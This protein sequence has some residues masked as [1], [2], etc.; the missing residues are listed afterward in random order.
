M[1]CGCA[2]HAPRVVV[3]YYVGVECHAHAKLLECSGSQS[4]PDCKK[5]VL[6]YD[7]NCEQLALSK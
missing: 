2:R 4:P 3:N 1:I 6:R 7:K 5:I